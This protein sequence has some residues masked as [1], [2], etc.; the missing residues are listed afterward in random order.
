M[1]TKIKVLDALKEKS[2]EYISGQDLANLLQISRNSV[3]KAIK[4]LQEEGFQID[5]KTSIGYRFIEKSDV[6]SSSVLEELIQKNCD[7]R[8]LDV[9]DSTNSYAKEFQVSNKPLLVVANEQTKGRGRLGREFYSP[10]SKGIYMTIAFEPD[11]GIDKAMLITTLTAVAVCQAFEAVV[12]IGPKI[13]WVNDIYM[14]N[15]KVCGILTEAESN[16]ETGTISKIIVGIG[17]NCFEQEFPDSIKDRATYIKNPQKEFDRN[18]LIAAVTNKFFQ[19]VDSFDPT[20]LLRDYKSRSMILGQP[21]LIYGTSQSALP[22]NGGRGIKARAI[23]I[24]ENGG[25]VVEYLEGVMS[26]QMETITSGEVTIRK[27]F[28]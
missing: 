6:I 26:R 19:L 12:G 10:S 20:K 13:K 21:I 8:V 28:Y 3:W 17:I 1:S 27:D 24:D 16:F 23:D 5:S 18:A 22:E 15:K 25:L 14:D 2:P 9:I 4:R 7:I 11:F